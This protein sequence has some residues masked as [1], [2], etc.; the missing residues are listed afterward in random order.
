MIKER[1]KIA[2]PSTSKVNN[3]RVQFTIAHTVVK[4]RMRVS[5]VTAARI[6]GRTVQG[7]Y[8]VDA[9]LN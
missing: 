4:V 3:K 1:K 9:G 6:A 5:H 8:Y 7:V 2:G